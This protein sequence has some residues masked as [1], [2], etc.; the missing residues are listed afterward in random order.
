MQQLRSSLGSLAPALGWC[1]QR[2]SNAR[3]QRLAN[4]LQGSTTLDAAY[5][6]Y[7]GIFSQQESQALLSHWGLSADT[8]ISKSTTGPN[9]FL[10]SPLDEIAWLETSRYMRN[11]LLRD[12][13]IFSMAWGLELRVPFVDHALLDSLSQIPASIRL[14]AGKKLLS[15]AVTNLPRWLLNKPKQ[16]F[17]FPFQDW[18]DTMPERELRLPPVP[19]SL[20]LR[21]WYR[22]WSLFVL[23]NWLQLH[24][25][26]YL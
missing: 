26:I 17:T 24:L 2:S 18:L 22:R 1:S 16:G 12:S 14:A 25:N 3:N 4:W 13:D 5:H 9:P 11:Q 7:R 19:S 23:Q 6:C 21:P 20:D 8:A 10:Q 15:D